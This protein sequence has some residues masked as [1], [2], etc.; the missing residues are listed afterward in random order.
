MHRNNQVIDAL[1]LFVEITLFHKNHLE[2][3]AGVR[4]KPTTFK[5]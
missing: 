4:F 1:L 3:L 5:L 2:Y